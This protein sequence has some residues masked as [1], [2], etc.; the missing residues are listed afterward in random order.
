MK[1]KRIFEDN[2]FKVNNF[3][4]NTPSD[5]LNL[6]LAMLALFLLVVLIFI[7]GMIFFP[8][9]LV[10]DVVRLIKYLI[11]KWSELV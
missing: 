9:C 11:D 4:I 6:C 2:Y 1:F 7:I 10:W 8:I 3:V 5:T